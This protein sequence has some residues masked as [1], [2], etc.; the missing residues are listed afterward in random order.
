MPSLPSAA[1][2]AVIVGL[3]FAGTIGLDG[4]VVVWAGLSLIDVPAPII[5]TGVTVT[6]LGFSMLAVKIAQVAWHVERTGASTIG[7]T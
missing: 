2:T 3:L 4:V 1:A 6:G 7:E 5:W